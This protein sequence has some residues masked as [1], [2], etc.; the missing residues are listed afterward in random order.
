MALHLQSRFYYSSAAKTA[1]LTQQFH[2]GSEIKIAHI[3][4][5]LLCIC[6]RDC[7]KIVTLL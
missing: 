3:V 7:N 1:Q 6:I 2:E 4:Y 5:L